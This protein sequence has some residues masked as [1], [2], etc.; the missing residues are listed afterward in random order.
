MFYWRIGGYEFVY[1][2]LDTDLHHFWSVETGI[3][4]GV[5]FSL[6]RVIRNATRSR[7]QI[8]GRIPG[9]N[10]FEN[11]DSL[12]PERMEEIEGC[13]IVKIPEPLTFANTGDLRNRLRRLEVYGSMRVHPS[14]P[15]I[16]QEEMT[17]YVILIC[18]V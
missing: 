12:P 4:L 15:R 10:Q 3:A 18:T 9:T 14:F 5:G 1:H 16:R 17:R 11:A 8:L 13:F 7:I 2:V 6:V